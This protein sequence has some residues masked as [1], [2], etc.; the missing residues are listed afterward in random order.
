[1]LSRRGDTPVA[2][3]DPVGQLAVLVHELAQD[4]RHDNTVALHALDELCGRTWP[5]RLVD[6][7]HGYLTTN[8][9]RHI[10]PL[11]QAAVLDAASPPSPDTP[12]V[13]CALPP[14]PGFRAGSHAGQRSGG[15]YGHHRVSHPADPVLAAPWV[16]GQE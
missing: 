15:R 8:D 10:A 7:R 16:D 3:D 9:L 2:V 11:R 13:S 4:D 5:D 14:L 1:G 6:L 12:L